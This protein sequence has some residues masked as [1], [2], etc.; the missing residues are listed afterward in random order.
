MVAKP[1]NLNVNDI[2]GQATDILRGTVDARRRL[3]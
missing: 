3:I 2:C 1:L